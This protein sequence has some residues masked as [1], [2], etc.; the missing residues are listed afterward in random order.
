M[1]PGIRRK[2]P[3]WTH[4]AEKPG[5]F[6]WKIRR[7]G[8][9]RLSRRNPDDFAD[10]TNGN[11]FRV[12]LAVAGAVVFSACSSGQKDGQA[13]NLSGKEV[14]KIFKC[15]SLSAIIFA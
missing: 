13:E 3:T 15:V 9:L 12:C 14:R 2:C 10:V 8:V 4:V 7:R 11:P 6:F 1:T 5:L